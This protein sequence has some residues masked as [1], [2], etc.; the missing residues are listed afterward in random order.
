MIKQGILV[1]KI[2][3]KKRIKINILSNFWG[4]R[5]IK[6]EISFFTVK[7]LEKMIKIV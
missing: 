5:C 6:N 2:E 4:S 7:M 1:E 3:L